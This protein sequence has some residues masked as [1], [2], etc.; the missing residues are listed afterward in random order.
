MERGI[1]QCHLVKALAERF[2][3]SKVYRDMYPALFYVYFKKYL[4]NIEKFAAKPLKCITFLEVTLMIFAE[5]VKN[6]LLSLIQEMASL[7][8]L[9]VKNLQ[10][11]FQEE[12]NLIL[13]PQSN[14]FFL[15]KMAA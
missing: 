9:F 6:R 10:L 12:E 8:W 15:W 13:H 7:P 14:L 11:I 4:T 1:S 5:Y 3:Q 2:L